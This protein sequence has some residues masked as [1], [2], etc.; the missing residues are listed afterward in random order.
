M[1]T[2]PAET[3]TRL[4]FAV[5]VIGWSGPGNFMILSLFFS[6]PE[7]IGRDR[8]SRCQTVGREYSAAGVT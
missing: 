2:P 8:I 4:G 5:I 3:R 1:T 7:V 6:Q